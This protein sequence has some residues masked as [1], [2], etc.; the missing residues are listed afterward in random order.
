M[1]VGG[2]SAT[3]NNAQMYTCEA[4]AADVASAIANTTETQPSV[5][6]RLGRDK[7]TK[8]LN[9]EKNSKKFSFVDIFFV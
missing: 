1:N 5:T 4:T 3:T 2:T 9:V 7:T 6:L 8:I